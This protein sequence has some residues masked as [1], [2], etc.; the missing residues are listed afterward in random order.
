[1][2]TIDQL[3]T[4]NERLKQLLDDPHPGLFTWQEMVQNRVK[5]MYELVWEN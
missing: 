2:T 3:K 1:M 5:V 4:E